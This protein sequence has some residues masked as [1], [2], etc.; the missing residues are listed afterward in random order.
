MM[1]GFWSAVGLA[2]FVVKASVQALMSRRATG[3]TR[4]IINVVCVGWQ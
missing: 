4:K 1:F 3:I 2:G